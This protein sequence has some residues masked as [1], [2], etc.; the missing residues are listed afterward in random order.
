MIS[1]TPTPESVPILE[2]E[3]VIEMRSNSFWGSFAITARGRARAAAR[4]AVE[5]LER[6]VALAWAPLDMATTALKKE[7]Q[8]YAA[9]CLHGACIQ[10][11]H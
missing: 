10:T 2:V 6:E 11:K 9:H 4:G 1:P 8:A 7:A 3:D 5:R